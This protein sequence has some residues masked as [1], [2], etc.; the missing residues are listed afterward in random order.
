M[1]SDILEHLAHPP[2]H[3]SELSALSPA[4]SASVGPLTLCRCARLGAQVVAY[5]CH[6]AEELREA[7]LLLACSGHPCVRILGGFAMEEQGACLRRFTRGGS[8][9]WM[10]RCSEE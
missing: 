10:K 2:L 6:T 9:P 7:A 5:R 3:F 4:A 1:P 8:P